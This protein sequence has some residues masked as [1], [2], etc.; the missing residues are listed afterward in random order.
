MAKPTKKQFGQM[1][2]AFAQAADDPN[3]PE[4]VRKKAR[5][6]ARSIEKATAD[7]ALDIAGILAL[8]TKYLPLLLQILEIFRN[9]GGS[10][11][12]APGP[13]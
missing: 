12:P 1:R 7:Q 5:A 4:D 6:A 3:V 11:S 10:T 9:R 2:T 13:V 8:L